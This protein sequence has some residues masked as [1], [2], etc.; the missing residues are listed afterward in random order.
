M[1]IRRP[2]PRFRVLAGCSLPPV[3]PGIY[4]PDARRLEIGAVSRNDRHPVHEGR[5]GDQRVPFGARVG[6]MQPRAGQR[7]DSIDRQDARLEPGQDMAAPPASEP[8]APFGVALF[9]V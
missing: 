4:E 5:G 2:G 1:P 6:H 3:S 8:A 9:H 7:D